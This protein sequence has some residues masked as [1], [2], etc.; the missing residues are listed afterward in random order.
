MSSPTLRDGG[1]RPPIAVKGMPLRGSLTLGSVG[2]PLTA[3]RPGRLGSEEGWAGC[4]AAAVSRIMRRWTTSERWRLSARRASFL[5]C[6]LARAV[7]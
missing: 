2:P 6:P 3:R 5:V 7:A 1:A 4:E